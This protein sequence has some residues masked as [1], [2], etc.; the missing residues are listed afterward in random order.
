MTT[1]Q[2]EVLRELQSRMQAHSNGVL[3]LFKE[4][5]VFANK[6]TLKDLYI[7]RDMS[8]DVFRKVILF[9]Y[10][11]AAAADGEGAE[12]TSKISNDQWINAAEGLTN[13]MFDALS[14]LFGDPEGDNSVELARIQAEQKQNEQKQKRNTILLVTIVIAVV[15]VA[16]FAIYL[17]N[18]K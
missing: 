5:G 4:A 12:P 2:K 13:G 17:K 1:Q 8:E 18:K 6:P 16:L 9:L 14:S 3:A 10:P 7:V 11:E 15:L